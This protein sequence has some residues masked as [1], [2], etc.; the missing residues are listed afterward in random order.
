M[1]IVKL[2]NDDVSSVL[3]IKDGKLTSNRECC[4]C[5]SKC[6]PCDFYYS[7]T[8]YNVLQ[9]LTESSPVNCESPIVSSTT[10]I[11]IPEEVPLPCCVSIFG[12]VKDDLLV[13]GEVIQP[14]LYV[15]LCEYDFIGECGNGK[16]NFCYSFISD[17]RNIDLAVMDRYGPNPEYGINYNIWANVTIRFCLGSKVC[18]SD[19]CPFNPYAYSPSGCYCGASST[20]GICCPCVFEGGEG[21][22]DWDGNC[23][24]MVDPDNE[25]DMG[26]CDTFCVCPL[27]KDK[28]GLVGGNNQGQVVYRGEYGNPGGLESYRHCVIPSG[29]PILIGCV[30]GDVRVC[31][32]GYPIGGE[33]RVTQGVAN[34]NN[35]PTLGPDQE[36]IPLFR[37]SALDEGLYTSCEDFGSIQDWRPYPVDGDSDS[38][39]CDNIDSCK[40]LCACT[41]NGPVFLGHSLWD[42]ENNKYGQYFG[43]TKDDYGNIFLDGNPVNLCSIIE[44]SNEICGPSGQQYFCCDPD[45][46]CKPTNNPSN[47]TICSECKP[48]CSSVDCSFVGFAV[49]N[50]GNDDLIL[51]E[52][53]IPLP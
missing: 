26:W 9:T 40:R 33:I 21:W 42:P 49:S 19:E 36:C 23:R 46:G 13:N 4:D 27:W 2:I 53:C 43:A 48:Y 17:S 35:L 8:S 51:C 18:N 37:C 12:T 28:N 3:V 45:I 32:A 41:Q 14:N 1:T 52:E 22:L 7:E 29:A 5:L 6:C 24:S 50:N 30:V 39:P 31:A 47:N 20:L 15:G 11:T 16:H 44:G 10:T 25:Y 38:V 34:T